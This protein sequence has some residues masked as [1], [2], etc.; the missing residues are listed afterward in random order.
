MSYKLLSVDADTKTIKG[1]EIGFLTGILYLAPY[2][3]SGVNL[4]PFAK[5]A[6]CHV[7]CLNT[8][9][10]G[11]FNNVKSA[12]LR[13]AKLFND[14]RGEFFA[15]LIEDIHKLK[16]QAKKQ[17]LQAVVRLNG[18]SDIEW[19]NIKVTGDYTI[20]NLFSDLQFYDYTKNPNR[21]NLPSNYD[22]TFS[23]SGVKSFIKFNRQALSNNMRVAT[24][25][26][27]MPAQFE[28]REVIN[29]DDH[30][31]RFIEDKNIIVGLKAK[32]KARQDKTGFVIA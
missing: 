14:N 10:R 16:A 4:C 17:N 6:E 8:A 19:E 27:I 28:G 21:K 18:T 12:R 31:A 32:G 1:R 9:G 30:D 13:R 7:A 25:F 24:V 26:K 20:F 15:Q 5:V 3:L 29:G 2:T 23:Y 22:L 11:N